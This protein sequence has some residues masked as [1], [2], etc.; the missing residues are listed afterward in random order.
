MSSCVLDASALLALLN[1]E[2]GADVVAA[3]LDDSGTVIGSVN[4]CEVVG[5]LAQYGM[6]DNAIRQV[7][8]QIGLS[9]HDFDEALALQAGL[10]RP[11]TMKQGLS[12]GD[13]CCLALAQM[14]ALPALTADKAWADVKIGAPVKLIR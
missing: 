5:K 4:Y 10:L 9:V 11:S 7:L 1:D 13:R 3:A 12:L 8:G 2:P 6:P 14:L